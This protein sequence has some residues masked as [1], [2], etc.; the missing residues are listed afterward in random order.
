M[1]NLNAVHI[2]TE[3]TQRRVAILAAQPLETT[4]FVHRAILD[5]RMVMVGLKNWTTKISPQLVANPFTAIKKGE[6]TRVEADAVTDTV[7]ESIR[8]AKLLADGYNYLTWYANFY[9]SQY[10]SN[11]TLS[12]NDLPVY[13]ADPAAYVAS[14][15]HARNLT[16]EI[17]RKQIDF[18]RESLL[19]AA[20]RR[21]E[22][23]WNFES[24]L[25]KVTTEKELE[26]WKDTVYSDTIL[27][28]AI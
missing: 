8:R 23:F 5:T 21:R 2:L 17:A 14:Y 12:Y 18:D 4:L 22:V 20:R 19:T 10:F 26:A 24:T 6:P 25:L 11:E 15:A 7:K 3:G 1:R 13:L 9:T 28:G 27:V 16:V